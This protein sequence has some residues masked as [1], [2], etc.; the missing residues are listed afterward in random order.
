MALVYLSGPD[1]NFASNVESKKKVWER[2]GKVA[3]ARV[4]EGDCRLVR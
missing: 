2:L 1:I 3:L 4:R